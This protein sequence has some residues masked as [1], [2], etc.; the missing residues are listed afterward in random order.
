MILKDIIDED[1]C[2]YKKTSMFLIFPKCTFKCEKECGIKCCQNS[3]MVKLPDREITVEKVINRYL[4]NPLSHAIVCGGMEPFD[5]YTDLLELIKQF[6]DKSEDD[7]VIYTGYNRNEIEDKVIDLSKYKNI[8]I[9]FGRYN[10]L[11]PFN[12][13]I[14]DE[15]LGITL[16]TNNQKAYQIS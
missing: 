9:K 7:I 8:I 6:R 5:S 14:Y 10:P 12:T 13:R 15:L 11:P 4:N 1:I 16:A 3:S 2:N